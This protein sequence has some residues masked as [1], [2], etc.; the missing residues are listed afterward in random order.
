MFAGNSHKENC[1][2]SFKDLKYLNLSYINF[3]G[4][5][6]VGELIVHKDVS[7]EVIEIFNKLYEI[8]YP[9][10]RMQ[11]VS[12]YNG[13]DFASIEANNT[14]SYN[15]RN[16]EGTN[17][18]SRHAFG[19]AIDI[20]PLQNPFISKSGNISHKE[21]LKYKKREHKNLNNP[22]DKAMILKDDTIVKMFK[23]YGWIWGGEWITIKDYQHFDKRK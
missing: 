1:P 19:K 11:L 21:S 13:N 18:W 4:E 9:I 12:D 20:N 22:N 17:K 23:S 6:K 14:S 15:C 10:E 16:V 2:I 8:K 7:K 5:S 3:E